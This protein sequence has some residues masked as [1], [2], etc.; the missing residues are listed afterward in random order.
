[1][2]ST[3]SIFVDVEH[4]VCISNIKTHMKN[5]KVYAIALAMLALGAGTSVAMQS[6]AQT[7]QVSTQVTAPALTISQDQTVDQKDQSGNDIEVNDQ[8]E[9]QIQGTTGKAE[10][11]SASDQN[12]Q[13][14]N[15]SNVDSASKQGE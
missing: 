15:G 2:I 3:C 1:M 12:E 4:I 5:K 11:E 14:E 10:S 6:F 8:S 13:E 7:P 9:T